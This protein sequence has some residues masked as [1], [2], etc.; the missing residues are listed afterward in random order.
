MRQPIVWARLLG[1]A[2]M[3]IER[4]EWDDE[5][6]VVVVSARPRAGAKGR[7]GRCDRRCGAYDRGEGRRR[8]RALDL[9]S[10]KA[11]IEAEAP[12]VKCP[13][14]GVVVAAV[15]WARHGSRFTKSFE[16]QA[17]WLAVHV[18]KT[19]AAELL[20]IAWRSMASI[21][22]L[23]VKEALAKRDMLAGLTSIGIDELS[24]QRRHKYITVVVDHERAVLVW[25]SEGRDEATLDAFFARLGP[26]RC[27]QLRFVS[28]D[29]AAW[30]ENVVRR[31]CP[32]AV[33]CLDTFHVVAW[34]TQALDDVRRTV[35]NNARR[36]GQHALARE[37]KHSR[38]ALWKNRDDLTLRQQCKLATIQ[39]TNGPLFRAYLLKEQ[40]RRVFQLPLKSALLML[41]D[42]LSW[43][44]RSRLP[45]FRKLAVTITAQRP[46][47]E[48]TLRHGVTN[49]R[50]EGINTRLR[51][52][53]RIA[54]GF[55]S[56][57]P[58][59]ALAM[60]AVGGLCPGLPGRS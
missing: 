40:L 41:D 16:Q 29:A 49:A 25:A 53:T 33:L 17:A 5:E 58:L 10:V 51:L 26:E 18:S 23:I 48:A 57:Q 4:V 45:S 54:F 7:C 22:V 37:L 44:R 47:I 60:L 34:S 14:H 50:T 20:R 9:G 35:W 30:I 43:A 12:R 13:E 39:R 2:A 56:A 19:A 6:S 55:H 32:Q 11:Y 59:I 36:M 1:V 38:F 31:R 8:W 52:L 21:V 46:R 3:V 24:V 27:A 28:A 42:W 15:P